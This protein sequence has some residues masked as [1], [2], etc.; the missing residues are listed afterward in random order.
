ML[1]AG[2]V[3]TIAASEM[4]NGR[5]HDPDIRA[6]VLADMAAGLSIAAAA[7]RYDIPRSTAMHWWIK[8]RPMLAPVQHDYA[9]AREILT[10][11]T[12]TAVVAILDG[13]TAIA[14]QAQDPVW[15]ERQDAAALAQLSGEWLGR[16][17]RILAGFEPIEDAEHKTAVAESSL[18]QGA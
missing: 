8:A 15:L 13:I 11:K 2:S 17:T 7:K 4:P 9:H 14:K 3:G 16:A 1:G 6:A 18:T 12:F 5:P 10:E